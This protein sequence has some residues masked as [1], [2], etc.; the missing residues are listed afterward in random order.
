MTDEKEAQPF[1]P[2]RW[3]PR[4]RR[5]DASKYLQQ[6]HGIQRAPA[7]LAKLAVIGGGPVHEVV[8]RTPYYKPTDLDVWVLAQ[9]K[10]RR[11]TSD[12]GNAA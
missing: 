3:P 7:T 2:S 10:R 12:R 9:L 5:P 1:Q 8:G 11:S 4:L 6:E